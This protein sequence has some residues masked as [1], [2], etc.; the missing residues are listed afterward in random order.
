MAHGSAGDAAGLLH[1]LLEAGAD[2]VALHLLTH[3]GE[4]PIETFTLLA[5]ALGLG[6]A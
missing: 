6:S 2:H 4:D 5:D 1:G 3:E